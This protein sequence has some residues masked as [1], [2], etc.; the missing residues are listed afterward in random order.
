MNTYEAKQEARRERLEAAA[1]RA[2]KRA[3]DAYDR[4]DMREEK[5]GIPL[6]QPIL[7]GHHSEGRHRAALKR[8][9]NAMRKSVTESKRA[10]DLRAK[11]AGVGKGGIS[12]DDPDAIDKLRAKLANRVERQAFMRA[13][14]KVVRKAIKAG[15]KDAESEGWDDYLAALCEAAGRPL[16]HAF[17]QSVCLNLLQP[18]FAGSVG[19]ADFELSNNNAQIKRIENRIAQ[20]E[21]NAGAESKCETYD[22]FNLV[23][24]TDANRVQF[25]FEGK[26]SAGIRACLKSNGFRW[27]PSQGAW[28]RQLNNAGR[29][30]ATQVVNQLKGDAA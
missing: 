19:F 26:P 16:N 5:S 22:G 24:N 17:D 20:L 8:A 1:D 3:A 11:A 2:E 30:A 13:A 10:A 9:D 14:N 4:A 6:G 27:A 15:V 25:I 28:Q 7:V 29:W 12:S 21:A 23:E 18:D